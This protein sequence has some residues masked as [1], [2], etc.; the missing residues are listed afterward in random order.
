MTHTGSSEET[1]IIESILVKSW[2]P[3]SHPCIHPSIGLAREPDGWVYCKVYRV[4]V[5][6]YKFNLEVRPYE[7]KKLQMRKN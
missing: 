1:I 5:K 3:G 2:K 7:E 6:I 4:I